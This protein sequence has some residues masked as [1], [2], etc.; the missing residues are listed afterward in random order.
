MA[1]GRVRFTAD[2]D[3]LAPVLATLAELPTAGLTVAPPSLEELFLRHY[4]DQPVV[5]GE[6]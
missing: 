4:G 5:V 6:R 1:D 3:H 2:S